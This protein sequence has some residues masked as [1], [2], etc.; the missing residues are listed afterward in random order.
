MT[1]DT[2][3]RDLR[4]IPQGGCCFHNWVIPCTVSK[5]YQMGA[6]TT[7]G[8]SAFAS[9]WRSPEAGRGSEQKPGPE[10]IVRVENKLV[11]PRQ[12]RP[13]RHLRNDPGIRPEPC[14]LHDAP[15]EDAVPALAL[16]E[17]LLAALTPAA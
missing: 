5:R 3:V 2:Y 11:P 10:R 1:Q 14:F 17:V 8:A 13:P 9:S 16:Q 12:K 4:A 7:A 15:L 6:S